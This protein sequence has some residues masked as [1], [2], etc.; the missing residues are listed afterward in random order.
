MKKKLF[1]FVIAAAI[2]LGIPASL[3]AANINISDEAGIS[4]IVAEASVSTNRIGTTR[5]SSTSGTVSAYASF[6]RKASKAICTIQLQEKYNGKWR[7]A[8]GLTVVTYTKV[9]YKSYSITTSKKF[10]LKSGKV[11]RAKIVFADTNSTG[12]HYK[13]RYTGSF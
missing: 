4:P 6:D 10:T 11:Y 2:A 1:S 12:T 8:T 13:T 5:H 7:K 9:V 3:G